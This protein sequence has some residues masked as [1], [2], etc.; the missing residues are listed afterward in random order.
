LLKS[1][2]GQLA[3]AAQGALAD[4]ELGE[5]I[6]RFLCSGAKDTTAAAAKDWHHLEEACLYTAENVVQLRDET[7]RID[8][9]KLC[10][11]KT[12][13][14]QAAPKSAVEG[15][16]PKGLEHVGK[17]SVG[18]NKVQTNF[19]SYWENEEGDITDGGG[20]MMRQVRGSRA[21]LYML[22]VCMAHLMR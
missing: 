6:V 11:I 19:L 20:G 7:E 10:T 15:K 21:L 9:E 4:E 18:S 16:S 3:R 17:Q 12:C 5:E 1:L 2:I 8:Q 14:N 13:Q 22:E